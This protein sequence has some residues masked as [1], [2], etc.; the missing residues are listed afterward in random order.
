MC[1]D[2]HLPERDGPFTLTQNGEAV[3]HE[4]SCAQAW[5]DVGILTRAAGEADL[6]YPRIMVHDRH[7]RLVY[8]QQ[9][10]LGVP[11]LQTLSI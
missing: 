10:R 6:P 1:K 8:A 2:C 3:Q 4:L 7:G 5:H 9:P 11:A